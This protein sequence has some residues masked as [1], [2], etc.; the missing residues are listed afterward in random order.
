MRRKV[1]ILFR[2]AA[3]FYGLLRR[4][5]LGGEV[6]TGQRRDAFDIAEFVQSLAHHSQQ[7]AR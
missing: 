5:G 6:Q 2:R 3:G 4:D 1:Q 7:T